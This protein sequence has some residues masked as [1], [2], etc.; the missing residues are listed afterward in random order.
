MRFISADYLYTLDSKPIK[1]GVLQ[2]NN[3]G[4]IIN[5]FE[6]K[7]EIIGQNI[8][9]FNGLLCPGF[10]NAHC[11]L[12]LS[13]L[14]NISNSV[15]GF[16]E[17][18]AIVKKRDKY[19]KDFIAQAIRGAEDQMIKNGIVAVGD[20]CNTIDT[21]EVKKNKKLHYYN[22]IESF[23][24]KNERSN[25]AILKALLIRD[26]FRN[27][28]LKATIT[29]HSAYSVTP[30]LMQLI[31][32]VSDEFDYTFSIHNQETKEENILFNEKKGEFL[33]WLKSIN[34]SPEIW[35]NRSSSSSFLNELRPKRIVFVH[36]TYTTFVDLK[37]K[38]YC[39]CPYANLF[40]ENKLPDYSIF[41][42]DNLCVGTDSLASNS[43]LS[44][45]KELALIEQ[46]SDYSLEELLKI[47]CKNGANA[48][49]FSMCG[50]FE[51]GKK[52]GINLITGFETSLANSSV[53]KIV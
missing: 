44:I 5:I 47:G 41:S 32:N 45:I 39:T 11:H 9:F 12:E 24:V 6:N 28:D 4:E 51:V 14:H 25:D 15:N 3:F 23:E 31:A 52:P 7:T 29:P 27:N 22:F 49:G 17:F 43:Q 21:L 8:E 20:I 18:L 53:E 2:I 10:I 1:N 30:D 50:T 46:N 16:S 19:S 33:Y 34:A 42:S 13:H 35:N 26:V 36:N 48:L 37:D 38:Y 40:I